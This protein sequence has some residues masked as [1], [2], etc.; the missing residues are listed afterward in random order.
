MF[1][2]SVLMGVY[3][4]QHSLQEALASLMDQSCQDFEVVVCDDGSRDGSF[5]ILQAFSKVYPKRVQLLQNSQ[6]MGLN[7]SLN[8]CL[9]AAR[10]QYLARMDGDDLSLP[11]RFEEQA[12][13][14]DQ[15]PDIAFVSSG[16]QLFDEQ[17]IWGT[18][19]PKPLPEKEDLMTTGTFAHGPVMMRQEALRAVGGYSESK[20]LL[21]V[22]D[23]HLW[24]K[25][26]KAGYRG[27]NLQK[28]LYQA[29]DDRD[30]QG[31]RTW[32]NRINEARVR[33][34]IFRDFKYPL[35]RLP[36]VIRPLLVGLLPGQIYRRLHR[37]RLSK[38]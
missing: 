10:G 31:R 15:H 4:C 34:M 12:A 17:G 13:F 29:R 22:E 27:A 30:A 3:N 6:N 24:Y 1:K 2:I 23:F 21:R 8:R 38:L 35:S 26:Y 5:A 37:G 11:S 25:L 32:Q 20:Q 19:R 28:P 33:Y 16:M 9:S 14:L 7:H 18:T 36:Q